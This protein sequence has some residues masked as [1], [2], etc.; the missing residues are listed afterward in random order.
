MQ[1]YWLAIIRELM[2]RGVDHFAFNLGCHAQSGGGNTW[3]VIDGDEGVDSFGFNPPVVAEFEK[4]YGVN[5][6]EAS[7]DP[8]R[9]ADLHGEFFTGFLRRIRELIGANRRFVAGMMANGKC[10]YGAD[11]EQF[12]MTLEWQKWID[13]GIADDLMVYDLGREVTGAEQIDEQIRRKVNTGRVFVWRT[14]PDAL[15][16][17]AFRQATDAACDGRL[18]GYGMK[19]LGGIVHARAGMGRAD[20]Q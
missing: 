19:E 13:E 10:G 20:V 9:L 15:E 5:I 12:R 7:F 11:A 18:D 17:D 3:R 1:D 4:R 6:L 14:I 8:A 2:E 16:F